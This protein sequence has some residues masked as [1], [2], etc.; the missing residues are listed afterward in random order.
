MVTPTLNKPQAQLPPMSERRKGPETDD[1]DIEGGKHDI[2][3]TRIEG[4]AKA[5]YGSDAGI[6]LD[7][8]P[9][10]DPDK[11]NME[12]FMAE[13]LLIHVHD[14]PHEDDPQF[15]EVTVNGIYECIPRGETKEISRA[16]VAVLAAAKQMRVEQ[17]KIVNSDGSAGYAERAVLRLSYPFSVMHD[18]NPRG[19]AWI[20]KIMTNPT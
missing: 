6:E 8:M 15:V 16:H 14:A 20:K 10:I 2:D 3:H 17:K 4:G 19:P 18:P 9:Y 7:T 12:R 1:R 11:M 5:A 13:K